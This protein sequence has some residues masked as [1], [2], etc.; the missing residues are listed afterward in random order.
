[1]ASGALTTAFSELLDKNA[2]PATCTAF[3]TCL[4]VLD[5]V[6]SD[7][8]KFGSI[9][10]AAKG[11]NSRLLQFEGGEATLM[12]CGFRLD[13]DA[14]VFDAANDATALA[15]EARAAI[16]RFERV[17]TAVEVVGDRNAP[18][19]AQEALK[20]CTIYSTNAAGDESKRKI[21]AAGK[22]LQARLLAADGG[23]AML[24][25]V[26]F[27]LDG[28]AYVY[29]LEFYEDKLVSAGSAVGARCVCV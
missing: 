28:E 29:T 3:A 5:N 19:V 15:S 8:A 18:A 14:Y 13:G 7:S 9:K 27:E 20:L 11:I 24:E 4:A 25:S 22:A 2:V 26:G 23:Q 6:V 1:M 16:S 21:P 17:R 12:A 10:A